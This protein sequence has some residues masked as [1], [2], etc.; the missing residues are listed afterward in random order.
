[1][2]AHHCEFESRSQYN[3]NIVESGVNHTNSDLNNND[4]DDNNI[5]TSSIKECNSVRTC[6]IFNDSPKQSTITI[7]K[8]I[9]KFCN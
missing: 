2:V 4:D 9:Y 5:I 7:Y 6:L 3:W 1:V 8:H